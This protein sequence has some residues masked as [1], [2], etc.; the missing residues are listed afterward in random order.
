MFI[1]FLR[2]I[3]FGVHLYFHSCARAELFFS[4]T[5]RKPRSLLNE[6]QAHP[7]IHGKP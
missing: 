6:L 3:T 5:L 1:E 4:F 7:A 2:V